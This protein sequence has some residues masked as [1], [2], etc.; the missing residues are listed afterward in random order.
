MYIYSPNFH[1]KFVTIFHHQYTCS[2][3]FRT[4]D[5]GGNLPARLK[6][7]SCKNQSNLT[8]IK[9]VSAEQLSQADKLIDKWEK[10]A[11]RKCFGGQSAGQNRNPPM[12]AEDN[13]V[14]KMSA[15][16]FDFADTGGHRRTSTRVRI[17]PRR[18]SVQRG[19]G[20]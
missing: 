13:F 10:S 1:V 9:R 4:L 15:A 16:D 19:T 20:R 12:S 11:W 6:I 3:P 17:Y 7:C 2:K 18:T 14:R 5:R 8:N